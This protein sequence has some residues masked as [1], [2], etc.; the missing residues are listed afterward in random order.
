MPYKECSKYAGLYLMYDSKAFGECPICSAIEVINNQDDLVDRILNF[1]LLA[2][3][4]TPDNDEEANSRESEKQKT[5]SMIKKNINETG[6]I[7]RSSGLGSL[8]FKDKPKK[9]D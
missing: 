8:V 2:L 7:I 4:R 1:G 9:R 5:I 3:S 6:K